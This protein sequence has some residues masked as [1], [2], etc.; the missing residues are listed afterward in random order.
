MSIDI[1][2]LVGI[3]T[4]AIVELLKRLPQVPL[5]ASQT[6]RIRVVAA[7]LALLGNLGVAISTGEIDAINLVA[8]TIAS[9]FVSF[10]TYK[11]LIKA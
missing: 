11:G 1:S 8:G 5:V 10:L 3:I 6:N 4:A 2:G 9:Y 7:I